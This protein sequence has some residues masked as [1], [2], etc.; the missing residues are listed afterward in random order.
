[1]LYQKD[2]EIMEL[3]NENERMKDKVQKLAKALDSMI[4]QK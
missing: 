2:H 3:M 4:A 1:L